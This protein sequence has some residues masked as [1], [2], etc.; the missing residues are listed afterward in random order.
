MKNIKFGKVEWHRTIGY[1]QWLYSLNVSCGTMRLE[2]PSDWSLRGCWIRFE[3]SIVPWQFPQIRQLS[4][5]Y[6]SHSHTTRF[7]LMRYVDT[8]V[9]RPHSLFFILLFTIIHLKES[10]VSAFIKVR[11]HGNGCERNQKYEKRWPAGE[12][13]WPRQHF[14][15]PKLSKTVT[16]E[17]PKWKV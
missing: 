9:S 5:S 10:M 7:R 15:C 16:R 8:V 13:K 17:R 3:H 11:L 1:R 14:T 12:W 6:H 2:R 4:I